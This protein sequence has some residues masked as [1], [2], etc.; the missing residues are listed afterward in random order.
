[1]P[2]SASTAIDD[3]EGEE[4]YFVSMTDIMVGLL[5]IFIIIIM[6]FAF[7][8]RDEDV[9]ARSVHDHV[10]KTT[11]GL[12]AANDILVAANRSLVDENRDLRRQLKNLRIEI[13]D[14]RR[15]LA[16]KEDPLKDYL[17]LADRSMAKIL[18]DMQDLMRKAG[19]TVEIIPEQ[20]ILR[21]S[22]NLLFPNGKSQIEKGTPAD[23]AATQ[24]ARALQKVLPCFTRGEK[25]EGLRNR[26]CNPSSAFIEAVLVEGHT[27]STPILNEIEP[28]VRDNLDLSAR[29]AT[30]TFR[31]LL[32]AEPD[33]KKFQSVEGRSVLN[34]SAFGDTRPIADNE[35]PRGKEQNRRIDIRVLMYTPRSKS[36][37]D[38]RK[39]VPD[40]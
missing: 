17:A 15:R 4:S 20:G 3:H 35:T 14:L 10:V 37:S 29:R 26:T 5:F 9:V 16:Q 27:D 36:I 28:G 22:N 7:Q 13:A 6:Y 40:R 32:E 1:M 19:F 25:S 34:V 30:N 2:R 39:L 12:M 11:K 23:L 38:I 31:R 33:L 21:L 24:L 8:I 18:K